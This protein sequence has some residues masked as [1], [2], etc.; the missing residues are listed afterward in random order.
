MQN[1]NY[2]LM[3]SP[4]NTQHTTALNR[5]YVNPEYPLMFFR[6]QLRLCVELWGR[7]LY[8]IQYGFFSI[9]SL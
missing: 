7:S 4:T 3:L 2:N 6:L 8:W 5:T 9:K 1:L